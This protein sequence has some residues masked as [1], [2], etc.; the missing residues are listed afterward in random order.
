ML[1]FGCRSRTTD[2]FFSN[3]WESFVEENRLLLFTAFSR[4]QVCHCN[5]VSML[6]NFIINCFTLLK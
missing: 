5:Y 4:D 2:F 6:P 1:F 3:E